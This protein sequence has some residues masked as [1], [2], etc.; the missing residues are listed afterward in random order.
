MF[1]PDLFRCGKRSA[2]QTRKSRNTKY[3]DLAQRLNAALHVTCASLKRYGGASCSLYSVNGWQKRKAMATRNKFTDGVL[4]SAKRIPVKPC[5][6]TLMMFGLDFQTMR[7]NPI[8]SC[9]AYQFYWFFG[10]KMILFKGGFA[11]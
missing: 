10:L 4:K 1:T 6:L 2:A 11:G 3:A 8:A 5:T 9:F 7:Q